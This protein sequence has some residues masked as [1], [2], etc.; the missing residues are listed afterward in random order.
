MCDPSEKG[1]NVCGICNNVLEDDYQ[2]CCNCGAN[3][4]RYCVEKCTRC[5]NTVCD[6]CVN[7]G[8]FDDYVLKEYCNKSKSIPDSFNLTSLGLVQV[9]KDTYR[10]GL[11]E[12]MNDSPAP[13]IKRLNKEGIDVWFKVYPSQFYCTFDVFVKQEN[14]DR[15]E[16]I[17]ADT[18]MYQG[19]DNVANL[20][21]CLDTCYCNT[22]QKGI[23]YNKC[24]I[25][26]GIVETR[27]ISQEEFIE[28]IKN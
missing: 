17:L 20:K 7:E 27:I 25:S 8:K 23:V 2:S 28:G 4:C 15:A 26:T 19:Y 6:N 5:G 21:K 3:L 11:H 10:K 16:K 22:S 1:V 9:N 13:I 24:D 18:D 12:G 14:L